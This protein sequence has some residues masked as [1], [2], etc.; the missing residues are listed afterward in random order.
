MKYIP[1]PYQER[2]ADYITKLPSIA[3]WL[4]PGH[5]KTSTT[6]TALSELKY[7]RFEIQKVLVI[8]P[9]KVAEDTWQAEG[10]K[11]DHVR[12]LR[13]ST[14]L[15]TARQRVRALNTPADVYVINRENVKW[16][17]DYYRNAWPFDTVVLDEATSFKN[18]RS[19]RWKALKSIRPHIRRMIELTGTPTSKGLIDLWAQLFLLDGGQRLGRTISGYRERYFEPDKR[20]AT[21]IFSYK[22]KP[23]AEEAIM[24]AVSDICFSLTP[25]ELLQLPDAVIHDFPVILDVKAR[26]AYDQLERDMLLQVDESTIDAAGAGVLTGKLLQVANGAVYDDTHRAV[27]IHQCKIEAFLE[28]VEELGDDHALVFYNFQH[29]RDRMLKALHG[30]GKRV[31]VYQHADDLRDW[32]AGEVDLL[33]AH[34]ASCAYGLNLQEGGHHII[35]FGLPPGNQEQF[36]QAN[37]RLH[38]SGQTQP[39]VIHRLIVKGTRDEDMAAVLDDRTDAQNRFMLTLAERIKKIKEGQK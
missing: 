34:P 32:N 26:K 29:D 35:W 6:L 16:L 3:L 36:E 13:F 9:K 1:A 19:Q 24:A 2:Y 22:P 39:V 37:D 30:S 12:H 17:V 8:A 18:N 4:K 28:L 15:G 38:R 31:R 25:D 20:N 21:T 5:R 10:Q 33:L 23:G 27:E 11:W 7:N 14:V